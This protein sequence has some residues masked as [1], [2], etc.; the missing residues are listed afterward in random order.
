MRIAKPG[1]VSGSITMC[2]GAQKY[3][4]VERI[5]S[6]KSEK[7]EWRYAKCLEGMTSNIAMNGGGDQRQSDE[8]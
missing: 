3:G 4:C 6:L 7:P 1:F 5:G 8:R 2:I